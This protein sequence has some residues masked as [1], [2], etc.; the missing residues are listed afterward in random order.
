MGNNYL[1][2]FTYHNIQF[3]GCHP[4]LQALIMAELYFRASGHDSRDVPVCQNREPYWIVAEVCIGLKES[5]EKASI[6]IIG[7]YR[8]F[9]HIYW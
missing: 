2:V 8:T 3:Q 1:A 4:E 7:R 6:V 5:P 9:A